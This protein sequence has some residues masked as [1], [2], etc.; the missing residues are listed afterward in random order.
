MPNWSNKDPKA[1]LTILYC[2]HDDLIG[3]FE[4]CLTAKDMGDK[5]KIQFSQTSTTRLRT[6]HLKRM[7]YDMDSTHTID[8]HL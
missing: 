7:H 2:M 3:E 8:K 5:I 6:L 1:C 4:A